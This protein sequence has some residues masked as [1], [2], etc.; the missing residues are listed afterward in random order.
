MTPTE[1]QLNQALKDLA[2]RLALHCVRNTIIETYHSEG[3]LSDT[4]MAALNKEVVN[5]LY[6]VLQI[7]HNPKYEKERQFITQLLWLPQGW[8]EPRFDE[9]FEN[10]LEDYRKRLK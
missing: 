7:L 6:S 5:K 10:A 3:K 8:D 1:D 4:E 9:E 2:L